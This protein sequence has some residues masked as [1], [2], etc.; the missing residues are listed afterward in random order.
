MTKIEKFQITCADVNLFNQIPLLV[1]ANVKDIVHGNNELH[2]VD[3]NIYFECTNRFYLQ[4]Q[5]MSPL[6]S[7][8]FVPSSIYNI[9]QH[10]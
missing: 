5:S 1:E 3:W 4:L 8:L 10:I 7:L 9:H 2:M 6:I